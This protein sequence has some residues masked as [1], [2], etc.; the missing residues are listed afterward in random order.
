MFPGNMA[1]HPKHR[2]ELCKGR[3]SGNYS[4]DDVQSMLHLSIGPR[5]HR[6]VLPR[7][8]LSPAASAA[9]RMANRRG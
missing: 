9:F 8:L 7:L 1:G 3:L 4:F 2:H 5:N 6:V